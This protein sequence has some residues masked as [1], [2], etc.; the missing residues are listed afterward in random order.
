MMSSVGFPDP[1]WRDFLKAGGAAFSAIAVATGVFL[2]LE[3]LRYVP[4][5]ADWAQV[6]SIL[7]F[8]LTACLTLT[9]T[10]AACWNFFEPHVMFVR[11]LNN[12]R[13]RKFV[14]ERISHMTPTEREIIGY[15]LAHNQRIFTAANDGGHATTLIA[16]RIVE[17]APA[18][19]QIMAEDN[20][21]FAIPSI[22]WEELVKQR[23]KFPYTIPEGGERGSPP[24]RERI[25]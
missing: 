16:S 3:H 14:R 24:W 13:R 1:K 19:N 2:I 22:V 10:L 25:W 18:G 15:L 9:N 5:I 7:V 6:S 12:H 11:A 4:A 23:D 8:L 21:P 17:F 20:F